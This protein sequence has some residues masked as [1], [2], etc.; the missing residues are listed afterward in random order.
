M[1]IT[2]IKEIAGRRAHIGEFDFTDRTRR[3]LIQTDDPF[4]SDTTLQTDPLFPV[5]R[6]DAYEVN[7]PNLSESENPY[8]WDYD[9][10]CVDIDLQHIDDDD[11]YSWLVVATY[12]TNPVDPEKSYRDPTQRAHDERVTRQWIQKSFQRDIDGKFVGNSAGDAFDEG[13]DQAEGVPIWHVEVTRNESTCYIQDEELFDNH[14]NQQEWNGFPP[15]SVLYQFGGAQDGYENGYR[16]VR[17]TRL[18]KIRRDGKSW[19]W[20]YALDQGYRYWFGDELL[21]WTEPDGSPVKKPILLDGDGGVL[22]QD[23]IG[24]DPVNIEDISDE[25]GVVTDPATGP[26]FLRFKFKEEVN[27]LALG[28][29]ERPIVLR[30]ARPAAEVPGEEEP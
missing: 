3:W 30:C 17:V 12:T 21:T 15:G 9:A 25:D 26:V 5:A 22:A 13:I 19:K 6:G 11:K 1:A 20:I 28:G 29:A 4:E 10:I 23:F 24:N 2:L 14:C 18:F 8:D 16:F 27:F 7:N